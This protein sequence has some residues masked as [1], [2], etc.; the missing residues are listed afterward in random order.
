MLT[1][2]TFISGNET[3]NFSI[4]DAYYFLRESMLADELIIF[5]DTPQG[6][7]GGG[8]REEIS[9]SSTKYTRI[10]SSLKISS[11]ENILYIDN[12][13]TPDI[14]GL[15]EFITE[16]RS[17]SDLYF[18][19]IAAKESK[20]FT[21]NLIQVDKTISH[22]IIRPLLWG[23]GAGISLPGQIFMLRRGKFLHDL[24][25]GDT[26]FDDLALGICAVK[27]KYTVQRSKLTLGYERPSE[28]FCTLIKQRIRWAMGYYEQLEMSRRS[29]IFP[30]VLLHGLAYHILSPL[31]VPVLYMTL[32]GGIFFAVM[33]AV[34]LCVS[35]F[36]LSR[37]VYSA[38]Y[39]VVF[40]AVHAVWLAALLKNFVK[41][42]IF[43]PA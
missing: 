7:T 39:F 14:F 30:L 36:R 26:V 25:E 31:F 40:Q 35:E 34:C 11:H 15:K 22:K 24:P 13:I 41:G 19:R 9:P 37:L 43:P 27:N 33:V 38:A 12:D 32:N 10:L 28:S 1:I 21:G 23:I 18:G 5:S 6:I 16:C 8:I 29:S 4:L 3:M 17:D 20:T 42:K 2:A